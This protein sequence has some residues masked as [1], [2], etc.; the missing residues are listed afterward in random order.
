MW[1]LLFALGARRIGPHPTPP[2]GGNPLRR[3]GRMLIATALAAAAVPAAQASR[4]DLDRDPLAARREEI[5]R[6]RVPVGRPVLVHDRQSGSIFTPAPAAR[7]APGR[8]AQRRAA[9]RDIEFQR[10]RPDRPGGRQ[11]RQVLRSINGGANWT[12]VT[13]MPGLEEPSTTFVDCSASEPARR[14]RHASRFD[15]ND[16]AWIFGPG[17]AARALAAGIAGQRRRDGRGSTR[18]ALRAT[19]CK[20]RPSDMRTA[21]AS[22]SRRTPTSATSSP[23]R[24]AQVVPDHEQTWPRGREAKTASAGNAASTSAQHRR[25]SGQPEPHV[26]GRPR[27]DGISY[28]LLHGPTAGDGAARLE[29]GRTA[30]GAGVRSGLRRRLRRRHASWRPASAGMIVQLDRTARTS[31]SRTPAAG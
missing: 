29:H 4:G 16:R 12:A 22:S 28:V 17:L 18:T 5:T 31:S 6:D 1:T 3:A 9:F 15:G 26:V 25:R 23:G 2:H 24:S 20:V 21:T 8:T 19:H 7:F 14:R 27:A 13:G 10:G 11:R 30:T